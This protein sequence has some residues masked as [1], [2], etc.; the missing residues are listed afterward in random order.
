M[1]AT[2][3]V[4][5]ACGVLLAA[6]GPSM[7]EVKRV[8]PNSQ[9]DISGSW[10]DTDSRM[11]AEAMI[12][13]VLKA[14]WILQHAQ[15]AGGKKP[16]LIIGTLRNHTTEHINVGTFLND[17]ER[18]IVNSGKATF[19]AGRDERAEVRDERADQAIYASEDT[20][21]EP[22]KEKGADYMLKGDINSI[23]DAAGGIA[24]VFYQVN[25]TLIDLETTEKV[26]MGEKKIKKVVERGS[27]SP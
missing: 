3:L 2:V 11:V 9:T 8:D 17:L 19:V 1:R 27:Y 22:G 24:A 10:N 26:W 15:K 21:K 7:P 14:P 4:A 23:V 16:R 25:L 13:D 12:G 20:R 6:C 18:A 5:A